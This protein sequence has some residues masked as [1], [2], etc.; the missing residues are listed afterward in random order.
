MHK[1]SLNKITIV[2]CRRISSDDNTEPRGI[3]ALH[4]V[5]IMPSLFKQEDIQ[6][7]K[8]ELKKDTCRARGFSDAV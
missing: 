4:D 7:R 8:A 5:W 6:I 1:Y 2:I 3:L